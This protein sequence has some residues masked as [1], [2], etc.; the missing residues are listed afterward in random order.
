MSFRLVEVE[1]DNCVE[2]CPKIIVADG[3]ITVATKNNFVSFL[4]TVKPG[5]APLLLHSDG[6][7]LSAALEMAQAIRSL[8]I[9]TSV[10]K[11]KDK[12]KRV[13]PASF[14]VGVCRGIAQ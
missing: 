6:G 10:A 13:L 14:S 7:D 4:A 12:G 2:N 9:A 8:G 3:R 1:T 11:V 5:R